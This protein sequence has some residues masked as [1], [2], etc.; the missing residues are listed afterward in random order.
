MKFW[1]GFVEEVYKEVDHEVMVMILICRI[2]VRFGNWCFE[3]ANTLKTLFEA[4]FYG[5]QLILGGETMFNPL[6]SNVPGLSVMPRGRHAVQEDR[7][8]TAP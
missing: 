7:G 5:V 6:F 1:L 3:E 8:E 4:S 2:V